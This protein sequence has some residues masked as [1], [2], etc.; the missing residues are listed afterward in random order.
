MK[1]QI[2]FVFALRIFSVILFFCSLVFM[3]TPASE[4]LLIR[5]VNWAQSY[6]RQQK[7]SFLNT[8]KKKNV[9][10]YIDKQTKN[11][12]IELSRESFTKLKALLGKQNEIILSPDFQIPVELKEK[13]YQSQRDFFYLQ[14]AT[15]E[16]R[17]YLKLNRLYASEFTSIAPDELAYPWRGTGVILLAL[18]LVLY[19]FQSNETQENK[20]SIRYLPETQKKLPDIVGAILALLFIIVGS[21]VSMQTGMK[22]F[23]VQWW[24]LNGICWGFCLPISVIWLVT[25]YYRIFSIAYDED[26]IEIT[27]YF[28]FCSAPLSMLEK[29]EFIEF[30]MPFWK[31]ALYRFAGIFAST[32]PEQKLVEV[33]LLPGCRLKF[34]NGSQF[35]FSLDKLTGVQNF[36]EFAKKKN[37]ETDELP[38]DFYQPEEW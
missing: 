24:V 14:N 15:S 18:S 17:E 28:S 20:S 30:E 9:D 29:I 27:S 32:A 8:A 31:K 16:K 38:V 35:E 23:S 2:S 11:R 5:T 37:I 34:S 7:K 25:G 1:S 22:T 36:I 13:I 12:T 10:D 33:N 6:E 4:L 21:G 26:R 19:F 3:V